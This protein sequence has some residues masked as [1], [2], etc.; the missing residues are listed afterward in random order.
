M[1]DNQAEAALLQLAD[2]LIEELR[3][4]GVASFAAVR[5]ATKLRAALLDELA[6]RHVGE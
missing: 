5:L 4:S 1:T 6:V 3:S 2:Q